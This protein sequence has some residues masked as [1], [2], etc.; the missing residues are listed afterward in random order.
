M[1]SIQ[2]SF[3]TR[4]ILTD[5]EILFKLPFYTMVDSK[6][7]RFRSIYAP[8]Y[9]YPSDGFLEAILDNLVLEISNCVVYF[10]IVKF[11][12]IYAFRQ[13][14]YQ[15]KFLS[16]NIGKAKKE[17]NWEP[18]L[19]LLETFKLTVDWYKSYFENKNIEQFT[20]KQ[21]EFFLKK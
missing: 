4:N 20:S 15:S 21:I 12:S 5:T 2:I 3:Y 7:K 10:S 6:S 1:S 17:L 9:N 14:L 11:S 16:L 8:I 13:T 19:N 18:R